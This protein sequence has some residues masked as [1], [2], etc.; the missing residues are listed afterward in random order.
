M[1]VSRKGCSPGRC[2]VRNEQ[3]EECQSALG[4]LQLD[5]GLIRE[6]A[7]AGVRGGSGLTGSWF[8][9]V[10][11]GE[12]ARPGKGR[13]SQEYRTVDVISRISDCPTVSNGA[14]E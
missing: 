12:W 13:D 8:K 1:V 5:R 9:S 14:R 11:R 10:L 4:C 3:F 2:A 6:K 7:G